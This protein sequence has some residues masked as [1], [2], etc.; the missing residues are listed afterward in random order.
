MI[1]SVLLS[2]SILV[3]AYVSCLFL[4]SDLTAVH[5]ITSICMSRFILSL[6]AVKLDECATQLR[7]SQWRTLCF[8]TVVETAAASVGSHQYD[9]MYEEDT[10]YDHEMEE[11]Q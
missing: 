4:S 1:I 2:G 5:R 11:T 10:V 9:T 6:L 8:A 3:D 7:S